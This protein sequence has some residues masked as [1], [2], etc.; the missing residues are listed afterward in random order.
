M[1][2]AKTEEKIYTTYLKIQETSYVFQSL[3]C[4]GQKALLWSPIDAKSLSSCAHLFVV[5]FGYK[6]LLIKSNIISVGGIFCTVKEK[7]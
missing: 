6:K 7:F 2:S 1:F 4:K 3:K 5:I